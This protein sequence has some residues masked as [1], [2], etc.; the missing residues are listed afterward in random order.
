MVHQK[1]ILSN[2]ML[3][4]LTYLTLCSLLMAF[5]LPCVTDQSTG[6]SPGYL[7]TSGSQILDASN[8]VVGLSGVN[9]SSAFC[10]FPWQ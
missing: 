4:G 2:I 3:K 1:Y 6:K 8:R 7:H 9:M 5:R 10:P